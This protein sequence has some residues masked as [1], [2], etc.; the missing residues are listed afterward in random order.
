MA[1]WGLG[2][3][4]TNSIQAVETLILHATR[5]IDRSVRCSATQ[6]LRVLS[7]YGVVSIAIKLKAEA[8]EVYPYG[9]RASHVLE[10]C[11]AEIN[12]GS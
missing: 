8:E 11:E 10:H 12:Y 5:D 2:K 9:A 3:L 1:A 4:K 6:A 7:R